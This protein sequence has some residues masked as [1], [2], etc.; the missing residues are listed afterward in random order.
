MATIQE[1]WEHNREERWRREGV[2]D[3]DLRFSRISGMNPS[4]VSVF[5]DASQT[6]GLVVV[7][8]CPKVTARPWHGLI[9]PKPMSLKQKTGTSGVAV[10]AAGK[11]YVSDYDLMCVWKRDGT[12]LKKVFVSSVVGSRHVGFSREAE[13]LLRGLNR[14]LISRLQHGCQDDYHSTKNPGVKSD[15][16]FAAFSNGV[17]EHLANPRECAFFYSSHGMSWPYD[18]EGKYAGPTSA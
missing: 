2:R 18:L 10:S 8:R 11:L 1:L 5:R 15:D 16:H 14:E 4:D 6:G 13:A 3:D 7:V 17:A 9:P 12:A